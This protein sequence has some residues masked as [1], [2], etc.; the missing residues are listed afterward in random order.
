MNYSP[1]TRQVELDLSNPENAI[2]AG[3][4]D[5]FYRDGNN[6]FYTLRDVTGPK[7]RITVLKKI[8]ALAYQNEFWYQTITDDLIIF[9]NQY[10]LWQKTGSGY[11]SDGW[12]YISNRSLS[13]V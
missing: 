8:F 7:I 10:E 11:N 12:T 3:L 5:Y 9:T 13:V 1:I 4:G 6:L 2:V